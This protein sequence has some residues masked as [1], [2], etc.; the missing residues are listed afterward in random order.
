MARLILGRL[1]GGVIVIFFVATFAFMTLQCAPGGPF[2]AE[3]NLPT[4]TRKNLE[5]RYNLDLPVWEQ[6]L[7]QS[8][9]PEG[10]NDWNAHAENV[11]RRTALLRHS[12]RRRRL[13]L[14]R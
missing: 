3:R 6:Y 13:R 4:E 1:F 14:L 2:D 11:D 9:R 10:S 5:A 7:I 8:G 12:R